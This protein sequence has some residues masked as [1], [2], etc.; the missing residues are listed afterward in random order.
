MTRV[1]SEATF[2]DDHNKKMPQ[3]HY[4]KIQKD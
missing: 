1:D 2:F 3:L 4:Q